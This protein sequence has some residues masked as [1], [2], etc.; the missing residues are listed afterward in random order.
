MAWTSNY[1]LA[2]E[3][4]SSRYTSDLTEA[5]WHEW[6]PAIEKLFATES[7]AGRPRKVDL[8]EV[9]NALLY[10]ICNGCQWR[11]LP[12]DFPK[13][14]TVRYYF[15]ILRKPERLPQMLILLAAVARCAF[16]REAM[17]TCAII[18]TQ[19]C[20]TYIGGGPKGYDAG[21]R[22]KGRKRIFVVDTACG[23]P[24]Y[25]E[26]VPADI[27][28]RDLAELAMDGLCQSLL[29]LAEELGLPIEGKASDVFG[30]KPEDITSVETEGSELSSMLRKIIKV[31]ADNGFKGRDQEEA[32]RKKDHP[33]FEYVAR[34]PNVKGFV[35]QPKRY[36]VEAAIS[37]ITNARIF[38]KEY[39]STLDC[40]RTWLMLSSMVVIIRKIVRAKE[41]SEFEP[42]V[43][44]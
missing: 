39:A 6:K 42:A 3:R 9:L 7:K 20:K 2:Y 25:V 8:R 44:I 1:R 12:K 38:S 19:S 31:L 23:I 30:Q 14:Q 26:I 29:Y 32:R 22:V 35:V 24:L 33:P 40:S 27:Q 16:G 4:R 34:D 43:Q 37:W 15:D 10:M 21:K 13:W 5:E 11:D 41:Q 36:R 18:D 17:P 28:D